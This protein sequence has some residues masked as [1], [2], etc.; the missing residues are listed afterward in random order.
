[1]R[2][3]LPVRWRFRGAATSGGVGPQHMPHF[4]KRSIML[5]WI[6]ST[7][8]ESP[9]PN[10]LRRPGSP[11]KSAALNNCSPFLFSKPY[12]STLLAMFLPIVSLPLLLRAVD[13]AE[14]FTATVD[15]KQ[16]SALRVC[17]SSD[18]PKSKELPSQKRIEKRS[19]SILYARMHLE[20]VRKSS[21]RK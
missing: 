13:T 1:M 17:A 5:L 19:N 18:F 3:R 20:Q 7:S 11:R 16:I 15:V 2:F 21:T 9:L 8:V 14:F 12:P 4:C 10:L 6:A